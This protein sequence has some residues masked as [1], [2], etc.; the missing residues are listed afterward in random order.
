MTT[1]KR[2]AIAGVSNRA[3]SMFMSAITGKYSDVAQLVAMLD[4]D[5]GRM[6]NYNEKNGL[7]LPGYLPDEFDQMV[8]ETQPDVIIVTC[9]DSMHHH[10]IVEALK[11]DLEVIVEKPLTIDAE[12]CAAIAAAAQTSRAT[13]ILTFNYRYTPAA[14]RIRELLAQG[15]VG[16]IVN[17]ELSWYLNTFHGKSYF[18]RWHRLRENS[19]G[20]SITKA[21]HHF[22]LVRWWIDQRPTEVLAYGG[23]NYY[24]PNGPHN[25]LRP[26]QI[27]DGRTC[28]SCDVARH[29]KYY[30]KWASL[31]EWVRGREEKLDD[32][33]D[34]TQ[35]YED[36]RTDQCIY[37]PQINIEDTY[38][39]LIKYEGGAFLSYSLNAS[40]PYEGFRLAINGTEGRIEY[41]ELHGRNILPFSDPVPE[42]PPILYL[43]LFGGAERIDVVKLEGDHQGAD[44]VILEEL[45]RGPDPLVPVERRASIDHGIDAVLTGVAVHRSVNEKKMIS[46]KAMLRNIFPK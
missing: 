22:D 37:D 9:P 6:R 23:L 30:M 14:T 46:V 16:R 35:Q 1:P 18:Q 17:V 45:F 41:K 13:V 28:G 24:G 34:S 7:S 10:Y 26:D 21:C 29:C 4:K 31:E 11:R 42:Q 15:K 43:P 33:L 40:V 20:L 44:P 32:H 39:A 3:I 27:G 8:R 25:P 38:G 5:T 36:Y 12:K 19:G 2:Y